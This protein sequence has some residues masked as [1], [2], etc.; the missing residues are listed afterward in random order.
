MKTL[1]ALFALMVYTLCLAQAEPVTANLR[2]RTV[3]IGRPVTYRNLAAFP[4]EATWKIDAPANYLT[5]EQAMAKKLLTV[6]EGAV[7]APYDTACVTSTAKT[8][9]YLMTGDVIIKGWPFLVIEGN[10]INGKPDCRVARD[11]VVPPGVEKQPVSVYRTNRG[12][13]RDMNPAV[14]A[15]NQEQQ[16]EAARYTDDICNS[17]RKNR[18]CVGAVFALNG[19]VVAADIWGNQALWQQQ[20]AKMVQAFALDAVNSYVKWNAEQSENVASVQNAAELLKQYEKSEREVV[21]TAG[22]VTNAVVKSHDLLGFDTDTDASF[23]HIVIYERR[24]DN[25]MKPIVPPPLQRMNIVLI[26]LQVGPADAP[27]ELGT[28]ILQELQIACAQRGVISVFE[29]LP[30]SPMMRRKLDQLNGDALA[31]NSLR[32][33]YNQV[34][35]VATDENTRRQAA[36]RLVKALGVDA[37]VCGAVDLYEFATKPDRNQTFIRLTVEKVM[38]DED[39][40]MIYYPIKFMSRSYTRSDGGGAKQAHDQEAITAAARELATIVSY[41]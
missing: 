13:I 11:T 36:A 26:P 8:P 33:N 17:L 25:I 41:P 18:H 31:Q 14:K 37:V 24:S 15:Q 38:L 28:R 3:Q 29:L 6:E 27:P 34:A 23:L 4:I 39:G 35:D 12:S 22:S 1:A 40:G 5:L 32:E 7:G 2:G 16:N 9:I 30:K 19:Q 21:S 20:M 10:L